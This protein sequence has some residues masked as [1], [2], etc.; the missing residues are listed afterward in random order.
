[1][2]KGMD[3]L[4]SIVQ[5]PAGVPVGTLAIGR[6][7]A[8]NAALLAA[9]IVAART[10]ASATARQLP[11]G[12]DRGRAGEPDPRV[13]D[14]RR[15]RRRPARPNVGAR[16]HPTGSR[17]GSSI[18]PRTRRRGTSP[19]STFG[20]YHDPSSPN[21]SPTAPARR[22]MSSRTCPSRP[23]AASARFR[24]AALEAAQDRLAEKR[25]FRGLGIPTVRIDDEV[26]TFPALLKTRRL[27]YDGK[28]QHLVEARPG[29]VP[30]HVLEERSLSTASSR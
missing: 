4:L 30:G 25:L 9:A 2:L 24:P 8:V 17:S 21:G 29:T 18:L 12:T 7:G 26:E 16:R 1:M 6:A 5:M 22:P 19:S 27:G 13:L 10:Q 14:R 23:P 11:R 20:A 15:A 3:S 28:G